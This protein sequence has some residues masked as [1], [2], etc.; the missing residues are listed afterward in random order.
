MSR[1]KTKFAELK[2]NNRTALIPYITA[3]DPQPTVTVP[4]MHA[5]V[6]AGADLIELG[7]PFSDPMADGPVIEAAHQRALQHKVTLTNVLEL[8]A[9]F[10]Q[11]DKETPIILMGYL[12]PLEKMGYTQFA[13]VA[14]KAGVDGLL[15][16]DLPPEEADELLKQFQE[17]K[18]DPIFL[19]APTTSSERM[20]YISKNASGYLYYVSLKGVTGSK[21]FDVNSVSEAIEKIKQVTT[22][23]IAVGFGIKDA[24]SA[25]QVA[26]IADGV[27]VGSA[28]VTKI[29]ELKEQ[30]AKICDDVPQII[31]QMRQAIDQ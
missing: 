26:K 1:I 29:A 10:R 3:G 9:E 12:N 2:N 24:H 15:I 16:V 22:L 30:I 8:V 23:P 31:K 21:D 4:L 28:L 13:K 14:A 5:L 6:Q 25:A 11:K 18:I 19:I 17:N 27:I 20:Q 7:I